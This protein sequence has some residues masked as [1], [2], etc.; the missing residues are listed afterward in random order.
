MGSATVYQLAK[1]GNNVLGI[2]QFAPPHVYGSSHGDTRITRQAIGEGEQYTPLALRSYEIW[3]EIEK[4]TGKNL[5]N[6]MGG[7][8]ISSTAKTAMTHVENFFENTINAAKKFNIRHEILDARQI[9]EKFPQFKIQDNESGYY[10]LKI[11]TLCPQR[12]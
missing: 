3:Q 7:L 11:D 6:I 2:D 10:E 8:I 12:L 5:L 9:R 1:R 4:E